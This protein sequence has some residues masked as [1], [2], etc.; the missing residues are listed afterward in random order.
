[1]DITIKDDGQGFD[2]HIALVKRDSSGLRG[3]RERTGLLDGNF[4][5][6]SQS[7][8]GT[9]ISIKLPLQEGIA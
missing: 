1:M 8:K 2:P 5:I 7:G 9:R 6:E 4:R 3:M